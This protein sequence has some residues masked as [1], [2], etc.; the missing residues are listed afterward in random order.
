MG[1]LMTPSYKLAIETLELVQLWPHEKD[2]PQQCAHAVR[3]SV[4]MRIS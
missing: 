1:G 3:S 4:R 2:L